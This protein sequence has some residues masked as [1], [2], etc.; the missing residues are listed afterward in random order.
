MTIFDSEKK[1]HIIDKFKNNLEEEK[2][3]FIPKKWT[4]EAIDRDVVEVEIT[5][6][7][8][9][10]GPEGKIRK[11][12]ERLQSQF[13]GI[14]TGKS[15]TT[16]QV[17][18]SAFGGDVPI[19]LPIKKAPLLAIGDRIVL[20]VSRK[21]IGAFIAH[22]GPI[23]NAYADTDFFCKEYAISQ[24]FPKECL[25]EAKNWGKTIPKEEKKR[26]VDL[27]HLNAMTIDPETAKD[28]DDALS[29]EIDDKGE[30]HLGVHIADAAHYVQPGSSLDTEAKKRGNSTYFP[31][32]CIPMLPEALSNKLCSLQPKVLRLTVSVQMHFAKDGELLDTAIV[33]S[34][35][36]SRKRWTYPEALSCLENKKKRPYKNELEQLVKLALL[37]K[38]QRKERGSIDFSLADTKILVDEKGEPQK[39]IQEEYDI[40][41]QLVEEFMLKANE[42]VALSLA[43]K[44]LPVIYRIHEA[45]K[46]DH[47]QDFIQSAAAL[48]FILPPEPTAKDIQEV[49]QEAKGSKGFER[50]SISFIRAMRLA[51]YSVENMGHYGLKLSHYTHFTSPI[52]RYAD[53]TVQRALFGEDSAENLEEIAQHIS[54]QERRSMKAENHILLLKKLR[55]VQKTHEKHPQKRY[56]AVVT[57]VKPYA[58]FFELK[59]LYL[60]GSLHLSQLTKDYFVFYPKKQALIGEKTQITYAFGMEIS[61]RIKEIDLLSQT[62]KFCL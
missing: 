31:N 60:A 53:L 23:T 18:V 11:I 10:K 52:R 39:L 48:G 5:S 38:G 33:R 16:Y 29:I 28:F 27:T 24:E 15:S 30:Y 62:I 13:A 1:N 37:L 44:N 20:S 47:L 50:L 7:D 4:Q 22:I 21:K 45:P 35:I 51:F 26:R 40:T 34:V 17:F 6:Y 9:P 14:I 42:V 49:F 36:K 58:L 43:K 59:Q 19:D 57:S 2:D 46:Q 32:V 8:S 25:Q 55:L 41:H 12:L 3:I 54:D 61:V 56:E